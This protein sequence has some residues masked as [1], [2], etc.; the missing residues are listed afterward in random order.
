MK[1]IEAA[2]GVILS[3]VMVLPLAIG[4]ADGNAAL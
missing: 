1:G 4:C 2:S 3:L